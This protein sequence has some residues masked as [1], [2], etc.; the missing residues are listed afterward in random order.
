MYSPTLAL[1]IKVLCSRKT[2]RSCVVRVCCRFYASAI[3]D[4][5]PQ[6]LR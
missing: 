3:A 6:G 4:R 2:L 5:L 1:T